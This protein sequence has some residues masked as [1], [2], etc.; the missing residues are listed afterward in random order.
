MATSNASALLTLA[1]AAR[2]QQSLDQFVDALDTA[3]LLRDMAIEIIVAS[4]SSV[5]TQCLDDRS[6]L[7]LPETSTSF[8]LWAAALQKSTGKYVALMDAGCPPAPEWWRLAQDAI[9]QNSQIFFGSVVPGWSADDGEFPGNNIVFLRSL[10]EPSDFPTEGFRKTF[11][12]RRLHAAG[13]PSPCPV[14]NMS[15][16]YRKPFDPGRYRRRRFDHGR[17]YGQ[18]AASGLGPIRIWYA[19]RCLA[20]PFLRILRIFRAIR[21]DDVRGRLVDRRGAGLHGA[22]SQAQNPVTPF[23]RMQRI[24]SQ[25]KFA[26]AG[27]TDIEFSIIAGRVS[28]E[29][30]DRV[31]ETLD[32]LRSQEG[33]PTYEVLLVDRLND[34]ISD[35]IENDYPEVTLIRCEPQADLPSMRTVALKQSVGQFVAVTEDHCVPANDWLANLRRL[36]Q[37]HRQANVIGGSVLNGV[38]ETALDWAT[39]LCEYSAFLPPV[40]E[41]T[42]E[43]VPGMNVAYRRGVF[44]AVPEAVLTRGFWETTLHPRLIAEGNIF[45][46]S[47]SVKMYH[48]KKFSL[49]LFLRQ[50]FIYSRYFAGIRFGNDDFGRRLFASI[51]CIAL[52][53]LLFLRFVRSVASRQLDRRAVIVSTPYLL[54]F[55]LVWAYGEMIGY[56]S[57]PAD[58]LSRIE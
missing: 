26:N 30:H 3:G 57:G 33:R 50:R 24:R 44:D 9:R 32:A 17:A 29:D 53:P 43:N 7:R 14:P 5:A 58:A 49:G 45:V 6:I 22:S 38:D 47:N 19:S 31:M 4:N 2:D 23:F 46:S 35:R 21:E 12:V 39:F 54:L 1:V 42:T 18:Q 10:L 36:F 56:L 37:E 16:L 15:V 13:H 11:F 20:L 25:M 8:Q 52:P 28:T 27:S 55:Y 34:D 51:A 40:D 48:C 41:G